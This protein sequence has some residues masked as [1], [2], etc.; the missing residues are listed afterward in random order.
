MFLSLGYVTA[1]TSNFFLAFV[2][3]LGWSACL[4]IYARLLGRVAWVMSQSGVQV[5]KRRRRRRKKIA[6][7]PDDW[8]AEA[9]SSP[10]RVI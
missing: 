10:A 8:G 1:T 4:I 2:T 7:G 5:R 3:G 9:E 6:P